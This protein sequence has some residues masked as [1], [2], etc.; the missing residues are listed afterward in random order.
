MI[1]IIIEIKAP[2]SS[3][4]HLRDNDLISLEWKDIFI[5][6]CVMSDVD[7]LLSEIVNFVIEVILIKTN[8]YPF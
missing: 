7:F 4:T 5:K 1:V 3:V 8:E 6:C 2:D